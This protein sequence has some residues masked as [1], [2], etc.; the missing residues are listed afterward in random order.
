MAKKNDTEEVPVTKVRILCWIMTSPENL[1]SKARH[2]KKTWGKRCDVLL[3][4][5]SVTNDKFPTIGFDVP[6][7]R[8]HL[9]AKTML[10]FRYVYENYLDE[11]DWFMKA[12]DDTYVIVENLRYFLSDKNTN[13]P[14]FFGHHLVNSL[15][16][17]FFSGGAGY[18]ISKAAL[19]RF[20]KAKTGT[21]FCRKD[22]GSEDVEFGKCLEYLGVKAGSS[23]D[24][25]G[26]SRFHCFQPLTHLKGNYPTWYYTYDEFDG[27]KVG[28]FVCCCFFLPLILKNIPDQ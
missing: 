28:P 7:G 11:A 27:K 23:I 26:K 17:G 8:E 18:I 20:G 6:E 9:T 19:R 12:D 15:K 4:M 24:A 5:S 3:F 21:K 16:Q 13:D 22:G 1:D 10:A 2:V 25:E 14:V